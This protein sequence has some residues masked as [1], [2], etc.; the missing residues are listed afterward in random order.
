MFRLG[1]K[2]RTRDSPIVRCRNRLPCKRR[3]AWD[4]WHGCCVRSGCRPRFEG[5]DSQSRD[6]TTTA[7]TQTT[8][9]SVIVPGR[10]ARLSP[11]QSK[12]SREAAEDRLDLESSAGEM[13]FYDIPLAPAPRETRL[14]CKSTRTSLENSVSAPDHTS[15]VAG[16]KHA[17]QLL[18][19]TPSSSVPTSSRALVE[20]LQEEATIAAQ[21]CT[22]SYEGA[23]ARSIGVLEL[24]EARD[25][26]P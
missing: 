12:S 23:S 25:W 2:L 20:R 11:M 22:C 18:S 13:T 9:I 21:Q 14:I 4:H 16:T 24:L 7:L 10:S 17:I 19:I 5:E 1:S 26:V 15:T 6:C 8:A 3:T